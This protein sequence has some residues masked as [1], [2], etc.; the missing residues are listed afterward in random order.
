MSNWLTRHTPAAPGVGPRQPSRYNRTFKVFNGIVTA[1]MSFLLLAA[2]PAAHTPPWFLALAWPV[3]IIGWVVIIVDSIH[4]HPAEWRLVTDSVL[5]TMIFFLVRAV[6]RHVEK[7]HNE[8]LAD[9]IVGA[10]KRAGM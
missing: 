6:F 2:L 8:H 4:V 9:A 10:Q 5:G 7:E 3:V 1:I